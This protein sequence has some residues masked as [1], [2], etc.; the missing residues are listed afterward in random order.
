MTTENSSSVKNKNWLEEEGK[1]VVDVIE[2]KDFYLIQ[3]AI[4]GIDIKKLEIVFKSNMLSISGYRPRPDDEYGNYLLQ[5]C[6]W[7]KFS[8]Q[9]SLDENIDPSH[10][11]ASIKDGILTI[12][13]PRI[14]KKQ[15]KV[16]IKE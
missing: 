3:S 7:G 15:R 13:I 12:R 8:R 9:I 4:A 16:E 2:N 5:E 10:I 6:Y 14:S 1:L 11:K